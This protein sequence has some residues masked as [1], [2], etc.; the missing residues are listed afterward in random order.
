MEAGRRLVE[1]V[2][3]RA[4]GALGELP[5][6]LDALRLAAGERRRRL[7]EV[8]VAETDREQGVEDAQD[9]RV[10]CEHLVRLH[11]R[12][13]EHLGDRETLEVDLESLA[14]V[15]AAAAL[16]AGHEDVGQEVHLDADLA[17]ALA[18]LAAPAADV[19]GEA[20]RRVAAG[21]GVGGRREELA[22]GVEE[23]GVGRGVGA[24][25]AADR[26]LVDRDHLVEQLHPL[27][28]V[29][30][31]RPR[32]RPVELPRHRL[33]QDLV[34]QGRLA[35]ARDAGDGDQPTEGKADVDTLEVVLGGAPH[36]EAASVARGA[37]FRYRDR[38]ATGQIGAGER[39]LLGF[40]A[41]RRPAGHHLPAV[42]ARS[43]TEVDHPVSLADGLLVVLD[44]HHR[45]AEVAHALQGVEE[46]TVVALVEA[47][48]RLV[49]DV[50]HAHQLRADLGGEADALALAARQAARHAVERQVVEPDRDQEAETV[51]DLAQDLVGDGPLAA[52]ERQLE[53]PVE[54]APHRQRRHLDQAA[55]AD[56]DGER[57]A[58]QA[59][60]RALAAGGQR[61]EAL[62]L[63]PGLLGAGLRVAPLE[64][65]HRTLEAVAVAVRALAPLP[66][67]LVL[68]VAAVHQ[69]LAHLGREA[70]PRRVEVEVESDGELLDLV[71]EPGAGALAD[72]RQAAAGKAA[73]GIDD[74]LLGVD[75]AQEAEA[76]AGRAGTLRRVEGEEARRDLRQREAAARA[77]VARGQR[78]LRTALDRRPGK[79]LADLE[80][81]L[82]RV[83]E[84][85][86][87][88][89]AHGQ[90]VDHDLDRVAALLVELGGRRGLDELAVDP[91]A[92]EALAHHLRE[93]LAV[94]ALAPLDHRREERETGSRGEGE[95]L[96][97]HLLDALR[98]DDDAAVGALGDADRGPQQA[99]VVVNLGHRADRRARVARGRLLL[100]RD[101]RRQTLDGVDVG[102]LHLVEE[103]PRV[104]GQRLHVAALALREEGVEGERG[105]AGA[106]NAGD[107]HQ[108]VARDGDVDVGQVVLARAAD[109]DLV[110]HRPPDSVSGSAPS[111]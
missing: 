13:V 111:R 54:G 48:R 43:G 4:G 47:D 67:E 56:L 16:V 88:T 14:V 12:Q 108:P 28:R 18:G 25:R 44:D 2:E 89:L 39:G 96:V 63:P 80:G 17:G 11:D 97:H 94:L 79:A 78:D 93:D 15:A 74:Q 110:L 73:F 42:A 103:L 53:E 83:G 109:Q 34:D 90:A 65:G 10:G 46:A 57:L 106:G 95:E 104:R 22:D 85:P 77:G 52:A 64:P 68:A 36:E 8:D 32:R 1:E 59:R 31:A 27:D 71:A 98:A 29:V 55:A 20:A 75:L 107:H 38:L 60:P 70:A 69:D 66:H 45:V 92:H 26:R 33:V 82:E 7:A 3:R 51:A 21:A 81:G 84:A 40:D 41:G 35:G 61:H 58:P 72:H 50:E 100:D 99:Q 37:P 24:R 30:A 19:E 87:D 62:E 86:R 23:L 9:L 5:R 76:G 49:E 91:R 102:L 6:E 105:L 101:R